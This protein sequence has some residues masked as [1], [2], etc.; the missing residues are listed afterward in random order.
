MMIDAFV[1]YGWCASIVIK[2][3]AD[4]TLDQPRGST[5]KQIVLT[6]GYVGF[7]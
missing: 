3:T 6:R 1:G 5:P 7:S 2:S 4:N